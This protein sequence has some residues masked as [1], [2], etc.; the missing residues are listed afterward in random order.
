MHCYKPGP[1][2][3]YRQLTQQ[4]FH[5]LQSKIQKD[6]QISFCIHS[7]T[8]TDCTLNKCTGNRLEGMSGDKKNW[9]YIAEAGE[10]EVG[11]KRI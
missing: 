9:R 10:R 4:D 6:N 7:N 3:L 2:E 11:G 5:T 8:Q 1:V